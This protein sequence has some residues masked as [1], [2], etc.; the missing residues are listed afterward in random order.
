[1][2]CIFDLSAVS[3]LQGIFQPATAEADT[4]PQADGPATASV[5]FMITL[6]DENDLRNLGYSKVQ[7]D[8][9]KPEEAR[10]IIT[11]GK[12]AAPENC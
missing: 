8:K 7:I 11:T 10:E 12:K 3:I 2:Q 1:M 9:L 5:K 4:P 6:Q